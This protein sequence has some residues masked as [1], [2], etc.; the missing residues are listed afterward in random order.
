MLP[1]TANELQLPI[2][3]IPLFEQQ[4]DDGQA[5]IPVPPMMTTRIIKFL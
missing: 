1:L 2:D 3:L 5:D 4:F